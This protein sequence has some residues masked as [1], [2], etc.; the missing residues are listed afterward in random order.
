M[1]RFFIFYIYVTIEQHLIHLQNQ[2]EQ[3]QQDIEKL[4]EMK[5]EALNAP[6][7]F[8]NFLKCPQSREAFPKLQT[9]LSIPDLDINRYQVRLTRRANTRFEQ[10]LEYLMHRVQE[11]QNQNRL[12]LM[13]S[14]TFSVDMPVSNDFSKSIG[15]KR[16]F[17]EIREQFLEILGNNPG[18]LKAADIDSYINPNPT[19][20]FHTDNQQVISNNN[21]QQPMV[22]QPRPRQHPPRFASSVVGSSE[23][24]TDLNP[25]DYHH[26]NSKSYVASRSSS[27]PPVPVI[28]TPISLPS[29][30]NTSTPSNSTTTNIKI[31]IRKASSNAPENTSMT[32]NIPWNDDEKRKLDYLLTVFPEEEIQARRYAKIAAALGTRTGNQ[33]ASRVQKIAAKAQRHKDR[34]LKNA[35]LTTN[36]VPPLQL[37]EGTAELVSEMEAFF[38]KSTDPKVKETS[39][40]I[41]YLQLKTQLEAIAKDPVNG[42]LHIGFKCD[43]CGIEPIIGARWTCCSCPKDSPPIDLCSLCVSKNFETV[44]HKNSHVMK[45][46]EFSD[47]SGNID[48]ITVDTYF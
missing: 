1:S 21:I 29:T 24:L 18:S 35:G 41:E 4:K 5:D 17:S 46:I 40:Y 12:P 45:K 33:V 27:V 25:M 11:V 36:S 32:H 31:R 37:E 6:E 23:D 43:C 16:Q 19:V 28:S 20:N 42:I 47:D 9:I 8:I 22:Y 39:E 30:S 3:A 13:K 2:L 7:E 15:S 14:A 48:D 26:G 38:M 34:A 44:Q 10:N